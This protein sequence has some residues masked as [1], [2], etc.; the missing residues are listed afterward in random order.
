MKKYYTTTPNPLNHYYLILFKITVMDLLT[1]MYATQQIAQAYD[2]TLN[3][4]LEQWNNYL[5]I[6][7]R[8][9]FREFTEGYLS[10]RGV[11]FF[12]R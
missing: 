3:I 4:A 8:E 9:L 12:F 6:S 11:R 2:K 5:E 7:Q 10:G 1:M